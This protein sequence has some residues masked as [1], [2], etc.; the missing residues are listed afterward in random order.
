M[1]FY[2]LSTNLKKPPFH[3]INHWKKWL[4]T[5]FW[6]EWGTPRR[7]RRRDYIFIIICT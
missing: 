6:Y 7:R 2:V 4:A 5:I 3:V 1:F